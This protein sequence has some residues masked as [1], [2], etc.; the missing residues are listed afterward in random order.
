MIDQASSLN[1]TLAALQAD[2]DARRFDGTQFEDAVLRYAADIPSWEIAECW[3][4]R[5]WPARTVVGVPLPPHEAG[6]DLVA[7]KRDGSRVAIQCKARSGVGSVTTKQVQQLAGA[8]PSSVFAERR[9]VAEARRST[10]TE[11][12]AAVAD[13]T[14]IDFEAALAEARDSARER[15]ATEPDPRT[16]QDEAVAACVRALRDGLPEHRDRW[17]GHDPAD[18]M[19]RDAARATLVLPC[20]T[21]KTRVSM[22]ILSELSEPGDLGVVLVPSIALIAQVRREYLSHIGHPVRTLAVCSDTTAGHVD[23]ERDPN[24]AAD[25]R[26]LRR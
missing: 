15:W 24:L 16:I 13:M 1:E 8:A 3:R 5:E 4:Y 17:C 20:G 11:D 22:R 21:G 19:P 23:I 14:F 26:D 18:W 12:A 2:R 6:I 7:V 25:H 10:A 9:M